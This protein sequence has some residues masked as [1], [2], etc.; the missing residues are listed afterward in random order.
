[1]P[2]YQTAGILIAGAVALLSLP[3]LAFDTLDSS[4]LRRRALSAAQ[5]AEKATGQSA[6]EILTARSE[7]LANQ[8]AAVHQIK[9]SPR[10]KLVIGTLM[11][12]IPLVWGA[13]LFF[14]WQA[15]E[16]PSGVSSAVILGTVLGL[17]WLNMV[18]QPR[19]K[20]VR[21]NRKLFAQLGCPKELKLLA[22]PGFRDYMSSVTITPELVRTSA[23][24]LEE[25][26]S[27]DTKESAP[28]PVAYVNSAIDFWE[29]K[30]RHP[31]RPR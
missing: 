7:A 2:W 19:L 31:V 18:A 16:V 24:K 25:S 30:Y 9:Y 11:V 8:L 15:T 20:T 22:V 13:V 1:M 10:D 4:L 29:A 17:S 26:K 6:K 3:K 5:A 12:G 28:D 21:D 27:P 23:R 14:W